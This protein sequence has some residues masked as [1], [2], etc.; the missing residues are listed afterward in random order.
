MKALSKTTTS[1]VTGTISINERNA[2][3][4]IILEIKTVNLSMKRCSRD[5][6]YSS[7]LTVSRLEASML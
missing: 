3:K 2:I 4:P 7:F 6:L 5:E 1:G